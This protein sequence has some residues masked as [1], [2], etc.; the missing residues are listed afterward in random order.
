MGCE[1]CDLDNRCPVLNRSQCPINIL[2]ARVDEL[3]ASVLDALWYRKSEAQ[4]AIEEAE[5]ILRGG[6]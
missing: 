4:A 3:K 1:H 5:Y 2:W 6:A